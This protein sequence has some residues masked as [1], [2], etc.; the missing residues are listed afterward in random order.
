VTSAEAVARA[1]RGA[2]AVI[3]LAGVAPGTK[4]AREDHEVAAM[5]ALVAAAKQEKVERFV[6]LSATGASP[7][8]PHAWSRAKGEA[9]ALLR[10][11][12]LP[13]TILRAGFVFSAESR[14]LV[15][16]V[17]LVRGGAKLRLPL[18]RAGR[19][20]PIAAG[21]V[22]I[23]LATALDH[24]QMVGRTL[25]LGAAPELTLE[26]L[27]ELVAQRLGKKLDLG[28]L[29]FSGVP[30]ADALAQVPGAGLSDAESWTSRFAIAELPDLREYQ[31][32]LPM[33]RIDF[34]DEL[35]TYPFGVAPPRP[36]DPLPVLQPRDAA[37]SGVELPLFIPGEQLRGAGGVPGH[38]AA[39]YGR[40]DPF[41]R[42]EPT[43][44]PT[45]RSR[46]SNGDDDAAR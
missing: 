17:Q 10:A 43:S 42:V 40:V 2:T 34:V 24:H 41:G 37:E 20:F 9:E 25:E 16:L 33:R 44:D 8:S 36:G 6:F 22:A 28:R 14:A 30:L 11:S 5:Q 19:M 35:R 27:L 23:A 12:A 31:Q 26:R 3:H 15:A 32:A 45:H 1:L 29:P 38:V 39:R 4:P 46:P 21:D 13:F 18:L 7:Q